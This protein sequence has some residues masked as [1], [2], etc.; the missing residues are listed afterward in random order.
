MTNNEY[1]DYIDSKAIMPK[2]SSKMQV[3]NDPKFQ[4]EYNFDRDARISLPPESNFGTN[5]MTA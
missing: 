5:E 1:A 4:S 2:I 3:R